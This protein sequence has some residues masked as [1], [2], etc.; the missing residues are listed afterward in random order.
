MKALIL[1]GSNMNQATE[2]VKE[3]LT[4]PIKGTYIDNCSHGYLAVSL[5]D[6]KRVMTPETAKKITGYSGLNSSTVY[7]EEDLDAGTFMEEAK[8]KG[9]EIEVT[10]SYNER[11][12]CPKNYTARKVKFDAEFIPNAN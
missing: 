3:F 9:I 4:G 11:F 2:R 1:E 6:F 10:N 12:Q 5:K 8:T 7:L